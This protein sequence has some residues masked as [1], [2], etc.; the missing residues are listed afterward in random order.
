M[1]KQFAGQRAIAGQNLSV[2]IGE[3][4]VGDFEVSLAEHGGRAEHEV[5]AQSHADV[6][7][8]PVHVLPVPK[9]AAYVNNLRAERIGLGRVEK[10]EGRLFFSLPHGNSLLGFHFHRR[11]N[12]CRFHRYLAFRTFDGSRMAHPSPQI[13][14]SA[15]ASDRPVTSI[16]T[17]SRLEMRPFCA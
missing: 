15:N 13:I 12:R 17:E 2:Q 3:A 8:V 11:W 14:N 1:Q 7:A 5:R 10:L 4:D 6:A 16:T 9:L